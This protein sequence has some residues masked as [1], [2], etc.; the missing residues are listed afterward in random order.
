M[1]IKYTRIPNESTDTEDKIEVATQSSPFGTPE[2]YTALGNRRASLPPP[3]YSKLHGFLRR[4]SS[5][6]RTT[7]EKTRS[8]ISSNSRTNS[9]SARPA[10][11]ASSDHTVEECKRSEGSYNYRRLRHAQLY[12]SQ[13]DDVFNSIQN[14][15]AL[16]VK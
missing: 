9:T 3:E 2:G 6:R 16:M 14:S 8:S 4:L 12:R 15:S 7:S 5:R 13:S 10:S 1:S 11:L